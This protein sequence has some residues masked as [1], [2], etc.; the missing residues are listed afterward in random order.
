MIK[1]KNG[2]VVLKDRIEKTDL[3]LLNDKI[4]FESLNKFPDE[5]I[6]AEGKYIF[7]GFI[8]IHFHGCNLFDFTL[9]KY[10]PETK[11]FDNSEKAFSEG[12]F[13]T[14]N[15]MESIGNITGRSKEYPNIQV[16]PR[17]KGRFK[18]AHAQLIQFGTKNRKNRYGK[19]RGK[20]TANPFM[21]R[22]FD[23]TFPRVKSDFEKQVA[24]EVERIA[25]QELRPTQN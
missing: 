16:G 8:D 6:N 25:R 23:K 10:N 2:N 1:I 5:T 7:P 4:S 11:Y 3:Y 12:R 19:N 20:V 9:G 17:A 21:Q 13:P 15:L 18:G 24:K 14:G 22:A